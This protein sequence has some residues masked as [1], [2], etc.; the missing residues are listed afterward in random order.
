MTQAAIPA[1]HRA[2]RP[3]MVMVD[4]MLVTSAA[5]PSG[6]T[7]TG[8]NAVDNGVV[9][10]HGSKQNSGTRPHSTNAGEAPKAC[11]SGRRNSR[12]SSNPSVL[13][14]N[15]CH[16]MSFISAPLF[17]DVVDQLA[18]LGD[19]LGRKLFMAREMRQQRCHFSAEHT[20]KQAA[21]FLLLPGFTRQYRRIDVTPPIAFC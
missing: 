20:V 5:V 8:G 16:R 17:F 2:P 7:R 6:I 18:Q 3:S 13:H 4:G 9:G 11:R 10:S 1:S 14:G 19:V 21:A 15:R 12:T